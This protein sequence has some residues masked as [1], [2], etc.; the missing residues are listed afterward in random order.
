[1]VRQ[2]YYSLGDIFSNP[3]RLKRSLPIRIRG[4]QLKRAVAEPD[5]IEDALRKAGIVLPADGP[6]VWGAARLRLPPSA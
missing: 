1:M 3:A 6:K 4:H 2:R 5:A